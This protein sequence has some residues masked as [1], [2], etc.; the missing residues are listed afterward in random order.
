M[1]ATR[2]SIASV[3][4]R[5][6]D[7][8]EREDALD[9]RTAPPRAGDHRAEQREGDGQHQLTLES[10][11][12]RERLGLGLFDDDRPLGTRTAAR[13]PARR[14]PLGSSDGSTPSGCVAGC[15]RRAGQSLL[16]CLGGPAGDQP[17]F[18]RL[19]VRD[20]PAG[21]SIRSA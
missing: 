4:Q 7:L 13:R 19:A 20:D 2:A 3:G 16:W 6:G 14:S 12:H 1:S 8:G 21:V 17:L 9:E 18:V 15:R 11:R 10:V 5:V